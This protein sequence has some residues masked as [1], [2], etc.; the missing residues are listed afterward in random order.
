MAPLTSPMRAILIAFHK[1]LCGDFVARIDAFNA[2]KK[3]A[4]R[5]RKTILG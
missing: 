4:F 5:V 2:S 1:V 3:L